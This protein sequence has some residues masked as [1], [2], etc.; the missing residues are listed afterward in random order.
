MTCFPVPQGKEALKN[1]DTYNQVPAILGNNKEELKIF[2]A[3]LYGTIP[4][5]DY[6]QIALEGGRQWQQTGVDDLA[7]AMSANK[8]QP[9][10]F[11]YRFEYGAYN[12]GGYNAWPSPFDVMIGASHM[13]E[14]PFL[15]GDWSWYG[16]GPF[17]FRPD[18]QA[19]W[20]G[21]SESMVNYW[22]SFARTG[23]PFDPTGV[24]WRPWSNKEGGLKHILLDAD[25]TQTLIQMSD[26]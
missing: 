21:L 10:V 24:L 17:I 8:G 18:N 11:A 22:A 7:A 16:L 25:A 2:M 9:D 19:G 4:D 20:Q 13:L 6:Q 3:G 12:P 15:Y 5:E 14:M 23:H 1:P 26:Q